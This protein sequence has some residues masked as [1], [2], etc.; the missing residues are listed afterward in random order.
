MSFKYTDAVFEAQLPM[1]DK[2][3]L[4]VLAERANDDGIC[5]PGQS[6]IARDTRCD[7]STA[8][9]SIDRHVAAVVRWPNKVACRTLRQLTER[10]II[11]RYASGCMVGF[12]RQ[13]E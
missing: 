5:W 8:Q 2:M 7:Y 10:D 13:K 11:I 12:L 6:C 1:T 4:W 3:I 9:R